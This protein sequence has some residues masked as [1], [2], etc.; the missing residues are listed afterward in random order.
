MTFKLFGQNWHSTPQSSSISLACV[1]ENC[2]RKNDEKHYNIV[3]KKAIHKEDDKH[4]L[5]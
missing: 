1:S 4:C 3:I 5:T 2:E